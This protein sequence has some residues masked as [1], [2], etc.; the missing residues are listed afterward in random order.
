MASAAE[1]IKTCGSNMSVLYHQTEVLLRWLTWKVLDA[2]GLI[3][4]KEKASL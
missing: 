1:Q 2:Q 3:I 4:K